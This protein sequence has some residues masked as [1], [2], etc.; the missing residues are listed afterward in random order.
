MVESGKTRRSM[1]LEALVR[2]RSANPMI[3]GAALTKHQAIAG[4]YGYSSSYYEHYNSLK[5]RSRK[6]E[7]MPLLLDANSRA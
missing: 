7:L 3:L 5:N 4:N 6:H 2:L 1:A